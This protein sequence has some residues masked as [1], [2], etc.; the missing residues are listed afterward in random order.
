MTK[1]PPDGTVGIRIRAEV[2]ERIAHALLQEKILKGKSH[3]QVVAEALDLY[4]D[5]R[6]ANI[7][8][9]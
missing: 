5:K 1:D 8:K 2:P 7:P 6:A 4:F 3:Q 9:S